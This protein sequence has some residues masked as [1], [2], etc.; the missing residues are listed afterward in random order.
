MI[1]PGDGLGTLTIDS[2][3]TSAANVLSIA[4]GG[5]FTFELNGGLQSDRI[6]L[7]NGAA[8]DIS[9]GGNNIIDFTDLSL[10]TLAAGNYRLFTADTANA[11]T[12]FEN[13][14]IGVGLEA[15]PGANLAQINND[16]VLV[17][18]PEP[19]SLVALVGGAAMLIGW[20]G[21]SRAKRT[22]EV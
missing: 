21:R 12:G 15:Y 17:I 13:L 1:T 5:R 11:F 22:A 20:R 19:G 16:I 7:I 8:G 9:F 2:L 6:A 3:L 14:M 4:S 10:G 18:V